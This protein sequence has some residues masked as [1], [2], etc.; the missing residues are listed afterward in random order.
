MK[1]FNLE[2]NKIHLKGGQLDIV[3]GGMFSG[4]S[5]RALS[6]LDTHASVDEKCAIIK[7]SSDD[8]CSKKKISMHNG[9]SIEADFVCN[10]LKKLWMTEGTINY[11]L[12]CYCIWIDEGQFFSGTLVPF[13]LKLLECDKHVVVSGLNLNFHCDVYD[14]MAK[15]SMIADNVYK[16]KTRCMCCKNNHGIYSYMIP[17]KNTGDKIQIGGKEKYKIYCRSCFMKN[18]KKE[19][20]IKEK[21]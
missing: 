19:N 15:L 1:K 10:D 12:G 13:V 16:L 8:R 2:K 17:D 6:I 18:Y 7:H 14:D 11:I 21:K 5:S 20:Y 3:V 9:R 4:K